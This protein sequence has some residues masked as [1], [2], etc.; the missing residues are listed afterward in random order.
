MKCLIQFHGLGKYLLYDNISR[1]KDHVK[2]HAKTAQYL[3]LCPGYTW[4]KQSPGMQG[5]SIIV[6]RWRFMNARTYMHT[7]TC[8]YTHTQI[9]T[10]R[11]TQILPACRGSCTI[12]QC[13]TWQNTITNYRLAKFYLIV[14]NMASWN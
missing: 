8:T 10:Y 2:V 9:H 1:L 5:S 14:W 12:S 4:K 7:H 13:S 3:S 6:Y 11:H